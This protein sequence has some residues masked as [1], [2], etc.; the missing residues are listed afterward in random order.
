M[1]PCSYGAIIFVLDHEPPV[2]TYCP[3][4]IVIDNATTYEMSVNWQ[5]PTA[6]DNSG[7]VPSIACSRQSGGRFAVPSSSLVQ[8]WAVDG[9]GNEATCSFRITLNRKC[10]IPPELILINTVHCFCF[11][12][13]V[14][15]PHSFAHSMECKKH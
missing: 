2:F 7:V 5:Q 14:F 4:D 1:F 10:P 13:C 12:F 9:T 3:D 11:Q 6:T 8:C 15:F